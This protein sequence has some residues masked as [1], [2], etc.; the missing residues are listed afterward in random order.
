M[1]QTVDFNWRYKRPGPFLLFANCLKLGV[2]LKVEGKLFGGA[3][4]K[5]HLHRVC[6]FDIE[7]ILERHKNCLVN[8]LLYD[9]DLQNSQIVGAVL[10][11]RLI[12]AHLYIDRSVT[13]INKVWQSKLP[14]W[15][16]TCILT[17]WY[18]LSNQ[19]LLEIWWFSLCIR[20]WSNNERS[21]NSKLK[22]CERLH[23]GEVCKALNKNN[24]IYSNMWTVHCLNNKLVVSFWQIYPIRSIADAF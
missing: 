12:K 11:K 19:F 6:C 22:L 18:V 3:A 13:R 14:Q 20:L 10:E 4:K 24:G 2:L 5:L 23:T 21:L 1:H 8:R 16:L 17:L 9:R 7:P 15:N